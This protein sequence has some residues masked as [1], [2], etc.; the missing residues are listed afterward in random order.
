M[1]GEADCYAQQASANNQRRNVLR[2]AGGR[3]IQREKSNCNYTTKT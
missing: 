3:G 2:Y 1:V